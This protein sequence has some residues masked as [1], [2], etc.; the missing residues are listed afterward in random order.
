MTND[1][2]TTWR[3]SGARASRRLLPERARRP[4]SVRAIYQVVLT[5]GI[6]ATSLLHVQAAEPS[7]LVATSYGAAGQVAGS[8]HVLDTGNGRWMVDCGAV[9]DKKVGTISNSI[10]N[11]VPQTLPAGLQSVAAVFLTH[12]HT[13]HLGRLP[14]LVD[15]G[16]AGP[17]YMTEA[18]AALAAP[19]LRAEARYDRV[20]PRH[21]T[22]SKESRARAQ[23][24]RKSLYVHW[25]D[26]KYRK[27]IAPDDLERATCSLQ[28]LIDRFAGQSSRVKVAVCQECVDQQVDS[29]LSLA[30]TAKYGEPME[31]GPGVRVTFLDAGHIPG[32]ASVLFEVTLDGRKR[33]VLFSGDLGNN[34]S[35]LSIPP[36]PAPKVDAVF[37]ECTYGP[38]CRKASVREQPAQFRRAV[39]ETIGKG[40][41][42]WIP[43]FSLDRTQKILYELHLAQRE[44]LLPERVPIYCPSPTA[45][46]A[47]ALYKDHRRSGWFSPAIEADADAFSP[48][49]VRGAVPSDR[50][51]PRPCI[52]IST[53]D[54]LIAAWMRR[55][56][57][58]LLPEP[59][60]GVF[61]VGYQ[62]PD[63]AG[64]LLL[65]GATKLD[66]DGQ[67]V[68]VRA[69]VHSFSC[70]S[71]HADAAEVDAW[72]ANVPKTAT[73]VLIHG[74]P[75]ELKGRAE[76]LR[77]QDRERVVVARPGEPIELERKS[78]RPLGE[79][80]RK[81]PRPLGELERKSPRPL[82]E[83]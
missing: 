27:E 10:D 16:F 21:W 48:R 67:S 75:E 28:D 24:N 23:S 50:R 70:F 68:A 46:E 73:V 38:I 30:R 55:L 60:T 5:W 65:R 33:R 19:M 12:A 77:G 6:C 37:V 20:Q 82:G 83:G 15:R 54:I 45:K 62:D 4:R 47:T 81:S 40:G 2:R 14:L 35:P 74:D 56:L 11:R 72:L 18:T 36:R 3:S 9:I 66:I 31:V 71:G 59:S 64:E 42:A 80:E 51:L 26:C 44:N 43:S 53:S 8:L 78:P 57:S 13:D 34:L 29:V 76:Q 63:T 79:L 17:I 1:E 61:L 52:I 69:K 25:R 22:W 41:V 49:D 39:G 58:D 32:S 7:K